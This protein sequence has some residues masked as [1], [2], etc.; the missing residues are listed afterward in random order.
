MVMIG[1][2][3]AMI[4]YWSSGDVYGFCSKTEQTELCCCS[5]ENFKQQRI[6][7]AGTR[8]GIQTFNPGSAYLN[9]PCHILSHL[10]AKQ[11]Q[12][13]SVQLQGRLLMTFSHC[14]TKTS[15]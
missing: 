10:V 3:L 6:S 15:H 4:D 11:K 2:D 9:A 1:D 12:L 13:K 8:N 7:D 5:W 14:Q